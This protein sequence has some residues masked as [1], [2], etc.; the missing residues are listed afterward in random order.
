MIVH[1]LAGG[2]SGTK[3]SRYQLEA[4][5]GS[6]DAAYFDV[7][8]LS[9]RL[10]VL[11]DGPP[12]LRELN[13]FTPTSP[14]TTPFE[15]LIAQSGITSAGA[16]TSA[17]Y[18]AELNAP[19]PVSVSAA[20]CNVALITLN[21]PCTGGTI[22]VLDNANP[23]ATQTVPQTTQTVTLAFI[24]GG[25]GGFTYQWPANCR[26]ARGAAPT[27]TTARTMTSVTFLFVNGLWVEMARAEGVPVR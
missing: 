15:P 16:I 10:P 27:D 9:G 23:G 6:K 18:V 1:R 5:V 4:P 22:D 2:M 8:P 12:V 13:L 20:V 26:F 14:Q 17:P 3:L 19:G 21:A 25:A 7:G 11:L 24:Q